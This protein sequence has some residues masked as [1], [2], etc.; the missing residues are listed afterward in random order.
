MRKIRVFYKNKIRMAPPRGGVLYT[1]QND[2]KRTKLAGARFTPGSRVILHTRHALTLPLRTVIYTNRWP[3][4]RVFSW[5]SGFGLFDPRHGVLTRGRGPWCRFSKPDRELFAKS[6]RFLARAKT[7]SR[8]DRR[9]LD[10]PS[11]GAIS[12]S[13]KSK[14]S[15]V[16]D[17]RVLLRN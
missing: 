10:P 3:V 15:T 4:F 9:F 7:L 5:Y 1:D 2:Q 11:R 12:K 14:W 16:G 17:T 8:W 13:Q 6:Y